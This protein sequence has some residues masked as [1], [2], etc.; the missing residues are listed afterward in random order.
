MGVSSSPSSLL[1]GVRQEDLP[2]EKTV[3]NPGMTGGRLAAWWTAGSKFQIMGWWLVAEILIKLKKNKKG[4][5]R[6]AQGLPRWSPTRVLTPL[7][8]A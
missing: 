3:E 6:S 4:C 8:P 5:I 2:G 1:G 7:E